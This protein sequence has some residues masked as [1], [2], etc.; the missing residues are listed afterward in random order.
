MVDVVHGDGG[1]VCV[2]AA[3]DSHASALRAVDT[4]GADAVVI[5][6]RMPTVEGLRTVRDLRTAFPALAIVV[7]SFDLD[8]ATVRQILAE[9][10]D[11]CVAKPASHGDLVRVLEAAR[12]AS[13]GRA[14]VAE[15]AAVA[16]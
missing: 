5:D 11:A 9:G 16:S 2:V 8:R 6:L 12:L 15:V 1:R 4:E 7:C 3:A 14:D 10:A 13:A